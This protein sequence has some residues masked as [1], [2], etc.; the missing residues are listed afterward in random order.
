VRVFAFD[1]ETSDI[2]DNKFTFNQELVKAGLQ[3]PETARMECVADAV[4]FF[5]DKT[6]DN[7]PKKYIVKPAVYDPKARTEILFLPIEDK[8]KQMAYLESRNASKGVPYV[9][10]EVLST[11]EYGSYAI[12]NQGSLTAF[13][14]FNSCASCLSYSQL[15]IEQYNQVLQLHKGLGKAMNLTGQLTLDLMHNAA[16]DLVPIECNP[17]IH[18]A[19]CTLEGHPKLGAALCDPDYT[20]ESDAEVVVSSPATQRYWIMDQLFLMAGFWRPKNCFKLTLAEML[21]GD[22]ALLAADDP[23]PFLAMYL[24]QIPSLLAL[25]L[26]SGKHW[27]KIDFCIGKIVKEGGD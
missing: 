13:E 2:L 17:R 23:M 26:I 18:S 5:E 6:P 3:C 10:Q 24:L 12:Y 8:A 25:E 1:G 19:I 27:L 9:M 22:D 21:R 14:F 11:P 16:G 4:K 20:P 15:Q 7:C